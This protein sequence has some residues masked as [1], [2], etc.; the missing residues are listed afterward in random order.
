MYFMQASSWI[1]Q[2]FSKFVWNYLNLERLLQV[3]QP[4]V[5]T[6]VIGFDI[7]LSRHIRTKC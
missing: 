7:P 2:V 1:D 3:D 6:T 4:L 5:K